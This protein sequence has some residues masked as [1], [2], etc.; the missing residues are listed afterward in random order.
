VNNHLRGL[1]GGRSRLHRCRRLRPGARLISEGPPRKTRTS[2]RPVLNTS[3][4]TE[5]TA[6]RPAAAV[7]PRRQRRPERPVDPG[8]RPGAAAAGAPATPQPINADSSSAQSAASVACFPGLSST[9]LAACEQAVIRLQ[10]VDSLKAGA[11][12]VWPTEARAKG[13]TP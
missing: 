5:T 12:A 9:N 13:R 3:S 4:R 6:G 2:C 7:R 1:P 11:T 8:P 10:E